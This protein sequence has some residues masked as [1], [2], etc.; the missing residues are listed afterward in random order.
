MVICQQT[1]KYIITWSQLNHPQSHKNRPY[2]SNNTYEGSIACCRLLPHTHHLPSL[3]WCR[4]LCQ[5]W[6]LFFVE[7][8]MK[9]QGTVL[10][11]YRTISA[12]VSC[13][14]TCCRRKYYPPFSNTALACMVC[15]TQFNSCC[16]KLSTSCLL[17]YGPN[18][19]ELNSINYEIYGVYTSVNVSLKSTKLK[20]SSSNW[21]N[22]GKAVIQQLSKKC[23]FRV[24]VFCQ[25][26]QKHYLGEVGKNHLNACYLGNIPAKNYQNRLMYVEV[27]ATPSIVVFLD[28]LCIKLMVAKPTKLD[29]N[30]KLLCHAWNISWNISK[31]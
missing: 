14:Q 26:V 1:Q 23:N 15:I 28:S 19:P 30:K 27:I 6:E 29:P 16:A 8:Q 12:N 10:V 31:T 4:S 21:L 2:A 24:S 18:R 9:C 20:K 25:V 7:P 11:E 22:Y 5:R 17:S 3:P 13:F